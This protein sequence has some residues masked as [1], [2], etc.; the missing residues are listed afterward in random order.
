[1]ALNRLAVFSIQSL[2]FV[3]D[4]NSI[5]WSIIGCWVLILSFC[6]LSAFVRP[7]QQFNEH[8]LRF[9]SSGKTML[10]FPEL[11][12]AIAILDYSIPIFILA[13]YVVI[14][15]SIN[16]KIKMS[17]YILSI[18]HSIFAITNHSTNSAIFIFTSSTLRNFLPRPGLLQRIRCGTR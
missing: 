5:V 3:F 12:L 7:T 10:D 9:D 13:V 1:M 16:R 14:Y 2:R 17:G 18:I 8:S 6:T 4:K 15:F 11:K